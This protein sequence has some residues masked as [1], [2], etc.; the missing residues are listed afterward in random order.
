MKPTPTPAPK[1][2]RKQTATLPKCRVMYALLDAERLRILA[3]GEQQLKMRSKHDT[4]PD[5]VP[6]LVLPFPTARQAQAAKRSFWAKTQE[7]RRRIIHDIMT[8]SHTYQE[9]ATRIL[10]LIAGENKA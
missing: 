2:T 6:C 7:Q 8:S 4:V 9:A 3:D 1:R 10:A 5:Y